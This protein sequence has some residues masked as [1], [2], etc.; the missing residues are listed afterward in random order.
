L[1]DGSQADSY[2]QTFTTPWIALSQQWSQDLL[3]YISWGQGIESEVAP[4]LPLYAN[5]GRALPTLKSR[6]TEIGLKSAGPQLGWSLTAFDI[7]RPLASDIGSCDSD[8]SCTRQ[9]DGNAHHSGIEAAADAR[10]S[11]W[12]LRASAMLLKARREGADYAGDNGLVP[13]NVA[14]QSLRLQ[15]EHRVAA[16]P[17]LS[18]QASLQHEG[19]RM[20]L[21]DNS[22]SIP[23]WTTA[24]LASRYQTRIGTQDLVWR[25]GV[26]NLFDQRAWKESPYQYSHVYLYPL[27]PRTFRT[28]VQASF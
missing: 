6:Q 19:S 3:G 22:L 2:R 23:G 28:S 9:I 16:L 10:L 25:L 21:P 24:G 26:D 27:A 14:R 15:A 17:G 1:T 12:T 11:A 8:G 7:H 20:V 4:A 18:L 13:P 5:A